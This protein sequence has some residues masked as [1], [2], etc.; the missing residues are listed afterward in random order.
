MDIFVAY[1]RYTHRRSEY[2][3]YFVLIHSQFCLFSLWNDQQPEEAK[4]I[5]LRDLKGHVSLDE[6]GLEMSD[7][8]LNPGMCYMSQ[9]RT[10][11]HCVDMLMTTQ[12][13]SLRGRCVCACVPV[14][15]CGTVVRAWKPLKVSISVAPCMVG[16]DQVEAPWFNDR[17]MWDNSCSEY[18]TSHWRVYWLDILATHT[19]TRNTL[20]CL[21]PSLSHRTDMW[22]EQANESKGWSPACALNVTVSH[23]SLLLS[24]ADRELFWLPHQ[25]SQGVKNIYMQIRMTPKLLWAR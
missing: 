7:R 12:P 15:V 9:S 20:S 3:D 10:L 14:S 11:L 2:V 24:D 8:L 19:H 5:E 25:S 4:R 17:R 22:V 18:T 21:L 16:G 23:Y 13:H 6:R 1:R